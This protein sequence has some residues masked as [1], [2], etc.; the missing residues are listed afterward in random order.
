MTHVLDELR[1]IDLSFLS[2]EE[3]KE[4]ADQELKSSMEPR[5]IMWSGVMHFCSGDDTG[6][7]QGHLLFESDGRDTACF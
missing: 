1:D 5:L 4:L 2:K 7:G 3:A 6:K